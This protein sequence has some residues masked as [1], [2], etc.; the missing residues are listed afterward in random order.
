[1]RGWF[2]LE[3]DGTVLACLDCGGTGTPVL[4]LHGLA[5]HAGEWK[6]TAAALREDHHV[7]ALDQRGHGQSTRVPGEVTRDAYVADAAFLVE[8]C[9]VGPVAVVGQS[10]GGHTAFLLAAARP[11]LVSA[12][13]VAEATPSA[14][15]GVPQSVAEWLDSWPVPFATPAQAEGFFGGPGAR[16]EAW[17]S[18]LERR[19]DGWWPR[20]DRDVMVASLDEV[21]Q[22]SF[23]TEWGQI[24]CPTLIVRGS[25]GSLGLAD[26]TEMRERVPRAEVVEIPGAGH[27]VH[28]DQ[29]EAWNDAVCRFLG[30]VTAWPWSARA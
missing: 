27:D 11:E 7:L 24:R 22:R 25:E 5:G 29:P 16:G 3:R 2:G 13:V 9:E 17:A 12:L 18:G 10:L 23:W 14:G 20:F 19:T 4:L 30:E 1:M 15:M 26:A 6:L 21:G 28:L 8:A